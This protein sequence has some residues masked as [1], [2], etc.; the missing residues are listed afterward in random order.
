MGARMWTRRAAAA[1]TV[2]MLAVAGVAGVGVAA[3]PEP[4]SVVRLDPAGENLG[5]IEITDDAVYFV[6][7]VADDSYTAVGTLYRRAMTT[8]ATGRALGPAEVIGRVTPESSF[9]VH[10]GT[11]AYLRAVDDRLVLRAPDGTETVPAWGDG[12]AIAAG[13]VALSAEWLVAN[14]YP[15]DPVYAL[16]DRQTGATYDLGDLVATP[17]GYTWLADSWKIEVSDDRVVF[18]LYSMTDGLGEM[19]NFTGV[20]TVALDASGPVGEPTVLQEVDDDGD[21]P[22]GGWV[23]PIG[24]DGTRVLWYE[25]QFDGGDSTATI[26]WSDA[27]YSSV[28]SVVAGPGDLLGHD[29]STAVLESSTGVY[30]R[31][32]R[33]VPPSGPSPAPDLDVPGATIG[34]H[35]TLVAF[36]D[37]A[38]DTYLVDAAGGSLTLDPAPL[39]DAIPFTDTLPGD[40]FTDEI[41]WLFDHGLVGGYADGTFRPR[42]SVN[43]DAMAA[44]LY[45]LAHDGADAPACTEAPFADVPTTHP[46]CGEIT[47]LADTGITTGWPDGTFRPASSI[48]R[49]AMAAFLVRHLTTTTTA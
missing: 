39:P 24:I 8:T 4:G 12:P 20:Y 22:G 46:F 2:G 1:A 42:A 30:S 11:V 7:Y 41:L 29:G 5:Q 28:T 17:P 35:G 38:H 18:G 3:P 16:V 10:D 9:A 36:F 47:W 49:Q 31:T 34:V 13:V 21:A 15:Y 19:D 43:R 37:A 33:W 27:P 14:D 45:R 40:P 44:F 25:N 6:E 32:V 23:T 48:E 26:H